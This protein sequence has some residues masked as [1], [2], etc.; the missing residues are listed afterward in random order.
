MVMGRRRVL[1]P[2][3]GVPRVGMVVGGVRTLVAGRA[4]AM[5]GRV[6]RR[7]RGGGPGGGGALVGTPGRGGRGGVRGGA[8]GAPRVVGVMGGRGGLWGGGVVPRLFVRVGPPPAVIVMSAPGL[9]GSDAAVVQT[10]GVPLAGAMPGRLRRL[11]R[12]D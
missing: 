12:G 6:G 4:G 3:R 8:R 1:V 5:G 10:R 11:R 7:R 2:G 9:V